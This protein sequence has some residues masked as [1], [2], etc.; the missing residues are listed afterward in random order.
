[1]IRWF[2][3]KNKNILLGYK[4]FYVNKFKIVRIN[5]FYFLV[6]PLGNCRLKY[7]HIMFLFYSIALG[8]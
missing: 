6:W 2:N 8:Y 5:I 7:N 3:R 1:M 4:I